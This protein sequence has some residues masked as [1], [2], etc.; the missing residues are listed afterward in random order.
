MPECHWAHGPAS[1]SSAMAA[2]SGASYSGAV[3]RR[4]SKNGRTRGQ[5]R[6]RWGT[7]MKPGLGMPFRTRHVR[8][9]KDG[10]Q[11]LD[12]AGAW[13]SP[14][15]EVTVH[16]RKA[17]DK[18]LPGRQVPCGRASDHI[19]PCR[20]N[21]PTGFQGDRSWGELAGGE[22]GC[23]V[24]RRARCGVGR[25]LEA[26]KRPRR[27]PAVPAGSA[28]AGRRAMASSVCVHPSEG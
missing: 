4:R 7:R 22:D 21:V 16:G 3:V 28:S 18:V 17:S 13:R 14:D 23:S 9:P 5:E 25:E 10:H 12:P 15:I 8:Y 11:C 26:P 20:H 2:Q 6:G 19:E 24:S 27:R 1:A